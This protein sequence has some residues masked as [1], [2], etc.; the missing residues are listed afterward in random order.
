MPSTLQLTYVLRSVSVTLCLI[1]VSTPSIGRARPLQTETEPNAGRATF[2]E[3]AQQ[4]RSA[5]VSRD[6]PEDAPEDELA[7]AALELDVSHDSPLLQ[8]LYQATRE[9]K[10]QAILERLKHAKGLI[11]G[12]ADLKAT[13]PQGR[14]ALHWAVFG[15]SYT[16]KPNVLVAY[17]E[18]AD[19]LIQRG[20]EINKQD[21]YQD[22]A[23]DYLLYSPSFEMQ[24]LLIENGASS[25]FLAAFYTFFNEVATNVPADPRRGSCSYSQGRSCSRRNFGRTAGRSGIQRPFAHRRSHRGDCDLSLMQERRAACLQGWR[26]AGFTRNQGERHGAVCR[27]GPGQ[28]FAAA[29]GARLLEHCSQEWPAHAALRARAC[30]WTMPAK[31]S[32]TTRFWASFSRM[33]RSKVSLVMAAFG[34]ANP[35]AGYTIKGVQTVYGLSLRREVLFPAGTDIQVQ[36]VRASMLKQKD[37]GRDGHHFP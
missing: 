34:A 24:T 31:R 36:V 27:K 29:P 30:M 1:A 7:P 12:G 2:T 3:R 21:V 26:V 13:D 10:E 28:V 33:L 8:D 25:G 11:A 5:E 19:A 20:V 22:T 32:A 9:T 4:P 16:T 18:I 23:L 17:E 35:I 37:R 15:S 6:I 14:T